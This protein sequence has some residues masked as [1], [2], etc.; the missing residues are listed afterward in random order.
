KSAHGSVTVWA[1]T[2][3]SYGPPRLQ[4]T[5]DYGGELK[6][7]AVNLDGSTVAAAGDHGVRVWTS[8]RGKASIDATQAASSVSTDDAGRFG[9]LGNDDRRARVLDLTTGRVI[10]T[11]PSDGAIRAI[12]LRRDGSVVAI[13]ATGV[14]VF[15]TTTGELAG[16]IADTQDV[17]ALLFSRDGR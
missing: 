8:S 12:Q 13:A 15:K 14:N 16:R 1:V 17:T 7:V 4:S 9:V 5:F 2:Q 6:A 10:L 3:D 11:I